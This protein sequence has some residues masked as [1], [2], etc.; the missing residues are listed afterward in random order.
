ML[1]HY[2]R[3]NSHDL[4]LSLQYKP[5]RGLKF[6]IFFN[7]AEHGNNYIYGEYEPGDEAPVMQDITWSKNVFGLKT[8]YE[9][10]NN[11]Y[12]FLNITLGNIKGFDV[13]DLPSSYLLW[14]AENWKE[15]TPANKAICV[16][17]DKE[18]HFREKNN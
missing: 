4:F 13:D 16:A 8:K 5:I 3:D 10:V 2:M 1:G 15:N 18:W 17:A 9:I 14:V 6:N 11:A 12:L 7:Y